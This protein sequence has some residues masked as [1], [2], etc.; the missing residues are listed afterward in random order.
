MVKPILEPR[1]VLQA[2]QASGR[3]WWL[4]LILVVAVVLREIVHLDIVFV[5]PVVVVVVVL[6]LYRTRRKN[7][8]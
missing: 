4:F 6:M 2:R 7:G 1:E 5:A 8:R 3:V